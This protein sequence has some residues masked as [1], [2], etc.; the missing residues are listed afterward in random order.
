MIILGN[1]HLELKEDQWENVIQEVISEVKK[2]LS[3]PRIV[4]ACLNNDLE[5]DDPS[6]LIRNMKFY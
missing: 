6:S 2:R 3:P 5:D 1:E 4:I